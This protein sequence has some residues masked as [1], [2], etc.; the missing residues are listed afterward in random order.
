MILFTGDPRIFISENGA[1]FR[2]IGGQPVM[3]AGLENY[4]IISLFTRKGYWGNKL[5]SDPNKKIGSDFEKTAELPITVSNMNK[6]KRVAE[7]AL[8]VMVTSCAA[9]S[10]EVDVSNP[11]G[12]Q[13]AVKILI[14][15]P[16]GRDPV[17]V[18]LSKNGKNWEFQADNPAYESA[19]D[20]VANKVKSY[21]SHIVTSSGFVL[22][23]GGGYAITETVI[24]GD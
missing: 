15:P 9:E 3:D 14:T 17:A 1:S 10:V 18:L 22:K 11:S 23:I 2:F 12:Y 21:T 4:A 5:V 24:T 7:S 20:P 13:K 19:P 6:L 16:G 8:S